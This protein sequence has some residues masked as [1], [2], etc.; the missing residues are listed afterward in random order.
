MC[1]EIASTNSRKSRAPCTSSTISVTPDTAAEVKRCQEILTAVLIAQS[2]ASEHSI[3][4]ATVLPAHY[5]LAG[6]YCDGNAVFS[7]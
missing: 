6:C 4:T 5:F 7:G 2:D 3:G 1:L